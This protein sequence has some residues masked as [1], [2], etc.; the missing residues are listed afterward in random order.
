M[1]ELPDMCPCGKVR[2]ETKA[3]ARRHA[4]EKRWLHLGTY[5]CLGFWHLGH[6]NKAPKTKRARTRVGK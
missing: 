3:A 1:T 5:Q 4:K 2:Y 6:A